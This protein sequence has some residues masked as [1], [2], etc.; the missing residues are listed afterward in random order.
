MRSPSFGPGLY[1]IRSCVSD[2]ARKLA[3]HMAGL[4]RA[5]LEYDYPLLLLS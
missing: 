2:R 3:S 1:E 5:S 4:E